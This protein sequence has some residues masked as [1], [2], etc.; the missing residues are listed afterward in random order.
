MANEGT[1]SF[2]VILIFKEAIMKD[3]NSMDL[4]FDCKIG[5]RQKMK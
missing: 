1:K 2:T 3:M 5:L 4:L